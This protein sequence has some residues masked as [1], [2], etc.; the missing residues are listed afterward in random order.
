MILGVT[1]NLGHW[2]LEV[3]LG[4]QLF[5]VFEGLP[6]VGLNLLESVLKLT[7]AGQVN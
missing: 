7:F 4:L 1:V 2:L 3:I 6:L 5:N